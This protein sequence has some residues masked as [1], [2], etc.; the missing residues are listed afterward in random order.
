MQTNMLDCELLVDGESAGFV[1]D[2]D[3][4]PPDIKKVMDIVVNIL[5]KI[6]ILESLTIRITPIDEN[7]SSE[8]EI[9]EAV[10]KEGYTFLGFSDELI[11]STKEDK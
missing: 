7:S 10:E 3:H 1:R 9:K 6:D 11:T 8:E 2:G 4:K 5:E